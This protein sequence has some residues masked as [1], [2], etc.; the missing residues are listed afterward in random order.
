MGFKHCMLTEMGW[1]NED[2]SLNQENIE[3]CFSGSPVAEHFACEDP[4]GKCFQLGDLMTLDNM[5]EFVDNLE[6]MN[7]AYFEELG[8]AMQDGEE[9]NRLGILLNSRLLTMKLFQWL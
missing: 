2:Y 5:E 9:G 3:A 8:M 1:L 4:V 6:D 7:M